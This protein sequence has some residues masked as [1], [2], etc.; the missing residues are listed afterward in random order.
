MF[1]DKI[2]SQKID[3]QINHGWNN[4]PASNANDIHNK[5]RFS[6]TSL[7]VSLEVEQ[8][9]A[10]S[11]AHRKGDFVAWA[12]LDLDEN[13][14]KNNKEN[15]KNFQSFFNC[16]IWMLW[17]ILMNEDWGAILNWDYRLCILVSDFKAEK[18]L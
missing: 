9:N 14:Q 12:F 13:M 16:K 10:C 8:I 18:K 4:L 5:L 7:T 2:L 11:T 17:S 15:N 3:C 1:R 6:K